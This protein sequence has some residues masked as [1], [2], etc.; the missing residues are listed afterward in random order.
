MKLASF[1][2]ATVLVAAAGCEKEGA[3]DSGPLGAS[4]VTLLSHIPGGN[5][6]IFGGNYM[7]MQ[8]FMQSSFGTMTTE[9]LEKTSGSSGFKAYMDCF[10]K[11]KLTA[12]GGVALTG[13]GVAMRFAMRGPTLKDVKTCADAGKFTATLDPDGK[14]L[15]IEIPVYG[16]PN[17]TGYLA[18]ADGTLYARQTMESLTG[19]RSASRAELEADAAGTKTSNATNDKGLMALAAK[20]DRSKTVWIV[21]S[22]A[23]TPV[24]DKVG[25]VRCAMG[26]DSGLDIALDLELEDTSMAKQLEDGLAQTR[27]NSALPPQVKSLLDSVKL[28]RDGGNIHVDAKLSEAQLDSV[29]KMMKQ[30]IGAL[31]IGA[32]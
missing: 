17:T 23:G 1:A 21:G 24:A 5:A 6:A 18:L 30:S 7:K 26:L 25:D 16:K 28:R 15:A 3:K 10:A 8:D 9:L 14:Y 20:T 19:M 31:P 13:D 27:K 4:D 11:V 2:L 32:P 22:G 12:A 29:T